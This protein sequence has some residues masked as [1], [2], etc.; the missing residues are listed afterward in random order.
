MQKAEEVASSFEFNETTADDFKYFN[1]KYSFIEG[2][3]ENEESEK[4]NNMTVD[5]D[6]HFYNLPVNTNY[7]S[8]HVPT[9]VFDRG[10]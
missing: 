5:T 9:N 1:S 3:E 7:S 6:K 2:D 10:M 8:V 4:Y